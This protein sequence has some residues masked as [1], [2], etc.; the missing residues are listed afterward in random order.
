MTDTMIWLDNASKMLFMDL[1]MAELI[2]LA[3]MS[4]VMHEADHA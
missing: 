4:G 2:K 1:P 3:R